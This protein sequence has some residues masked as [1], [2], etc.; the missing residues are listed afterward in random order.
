VDRRNLRRLAGPMGLLDR[1]AVTVSYRFPAVAEPAG[2]QRTITPLTASQ[3]RVLP[4]HR[5][6]TAYPGELSR[7]RLELQ[8]HDCGRSW[9]A[10][11]AAQVLRLRCGGFG[12]RATPGENGGAHRGS[13]KRSSQGATT[14]S[15]LGVTR[16]GWI[17]GRGTRSRRYAWDCAVTR[18]WRT[19]VVRPG[20][21]TID[22]VDSEDRAA[23]LVKAEDEYAPIYAHSI[24]RISRAGRRHAGYGPTSGPTSRRG[25][26]SSTISAL[27]MWLMPP[28]PR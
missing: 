12:E 9:Q 14:L 6:L 17:R 25:S 2:C 19:I 8:L 5:F 22:R 13:P 28:V 21:A 11:D 24:P 4:L 7:F 16:D 20:S 10:I 15:D 27:C 1:R 23:P 18:F 3:P 26:T